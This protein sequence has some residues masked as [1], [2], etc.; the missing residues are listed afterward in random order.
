MAGT[1]LQTSSVAR[2]SLKLVQSRQ[3]IFQRDLMSQIQWNAQKWMQLWKAFLVENDGAKEW[4]HNFF[5][6]G[7]ALVVV[8][9]QQ[10]L[11]L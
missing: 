2:T 4:A 7:K 10:A 9:T 11:W 8:D 6:K 1:T 3:I 5:G